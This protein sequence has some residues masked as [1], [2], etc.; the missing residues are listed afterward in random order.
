VKAIGHTKACPIT[1][2]NAL[3]ELELE[4]P[5]PGPRDLLVQVRGISVNPVDVKVRELMEPDSPHRILGYD[6]AGVVTAVGSDVTRFKPGEEV[7]Y[8][9]FRTP[10]E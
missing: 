9:T 8:R 3:I 7:F 6:A 4:K 2:E 10:I 5:Q 1:A